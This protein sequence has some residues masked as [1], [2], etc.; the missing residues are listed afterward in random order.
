M[1]Q[2]IHTPTTSE[3]INRFAWYGETLY[4]EFKKTREV[5]EY[6]EVPESNF[7]EMCQAKSAGSYFHAFIKKVFEA[8]KLTRQQALALGFESEVTLEG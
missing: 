6:P 4:I 2:I 7:Q 3:N 8:K 5:Y 1:L